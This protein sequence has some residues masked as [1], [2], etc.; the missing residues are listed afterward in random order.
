MTSPTKINFKVYQGSTF[1]ET[2]R[3]ESSTKV[4]ATITDISKTA[5]VII[6]AANHG[7]PEG[8]RFKVTGALGMKEINSDNYIIATNADTNTITVNNIN[9]L[10]YTTYTGSGVLEYNQPVD[11]AGYTARMQIRTKLDSDTIV[12]ELTTENSGIVIN[13]ATKTI[14]LVIPASTTETFNFTTG[15][16]SIELVNGSEV[17]PFA[18]G[19]ITLVKEVT[20]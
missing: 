4:Y 16:Y 15:V 3:W 10:N 17:T 14:E 13:N 7:V 12:H 6:T 8:W 9:A 1:R 11:L 19:S 18:N 20:R 5:P 2:L